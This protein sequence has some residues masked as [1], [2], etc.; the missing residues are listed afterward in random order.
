M[1]DIVMLIEH[2][3]M[4]ST[5][6]ISICI[7]HHAHSTYHDGAKF[8]HNVVMSIE[9]YVYDDGHPAQCLHA[10]CGLDIVVMPIIGF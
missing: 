2:H 3:F 8:V 10:Q 7:A 1:H 6:R 5:V 4:I 9:L